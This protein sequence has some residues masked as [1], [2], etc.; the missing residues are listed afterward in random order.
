MHVHTCTQGSLACGDQL[1]GRS[2]GV[3]DGQ[4][5]GRGRLGG[6]GHCWLLGR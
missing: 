4:H 1:R 5:G 6:D 2:G 3:E